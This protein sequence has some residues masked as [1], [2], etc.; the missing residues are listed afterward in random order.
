MKPEDVKLVGSELQSALNIVREYLS[1][2]DKVLDSILKG[3]MKMTTTKKEYNEKLNPGEAPQ[4]YVNTWS[5]RKERREDRKAEKQ[6]IKET[7]KN[8]KKKKDIIVD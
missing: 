5:T 8:N 1:D 7:R 2:E 6:R 3:W 4:G